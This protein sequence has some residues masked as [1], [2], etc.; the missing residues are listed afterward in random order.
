MKTLQQINAM[1]RRAQMRSNA[2]EARVEIHPDGFGTFAQRTKRAVTYLKCAI[3]YR[4]M[5]KAW[6]QSSKTPS[7][8][9]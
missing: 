2:L 9:L 1:S 7:E 8:R 6:E 5:A 3:N 4:E